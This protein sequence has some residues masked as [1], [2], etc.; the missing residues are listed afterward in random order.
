MGIAAVMDPDGTARTVRFDVVEECG[1][2]SPGVDG[3][4]G[5]DEDV[6]GRL[7]GAASAVVV[8]SS[9]TSFPRSS[10]SLGRV[11][12]VATGGLVVEEVGSTT[13]VE[14][15]VGGLVVVAVGVSMVVVVVGGDEN[16]ASTATLSIT[17]YE[18]RP[19]ASTI[20]NL[21]MVSGVAKSLI[22]SFLWNLRPPSSKPK[23][24]VVRVFHGSPP[25]G[26]TRTTALPPESSAS[27]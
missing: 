18:S 4:D 7:V 26:E 10:T 2:A 8:V 15:A 16:V 13:V 11:V 14:V 19:S 17:Q 27:S 6:E 9:G 3:A 25:S 24:I 5:V 20:M 23:R 1:S 22:G 21:M 12:V